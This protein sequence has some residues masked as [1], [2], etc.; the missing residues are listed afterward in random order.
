ML[1]EPRT[2]GAGRNGPSVTPRH[3]V[4]TQKTL[5]WSI[6]SPHVPCRPDG[7]ARGAARR[8]VRM[9]PELLRLGSE[10]GRGR[11]AGD[12]PEAPRRPRAL[13]RVLDLP[14]V[15]VRR[16]RADRPGSATPGSAAAL[17]SARGVGAR[18]RGGGPPARSCGG[19][20]SGRRNRPA[21]GRTGGGVGGPTPRPAPPGL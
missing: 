17:A 5:I 19:P 8:S 12:L 15:R 14:H 21:G 7:Q 20:R 2:I 10:R 9:G 18:P 13:R 1:L 4:A 3:I 16:D 6:P 11:A